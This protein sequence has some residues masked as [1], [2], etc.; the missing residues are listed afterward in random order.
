MWTDGGRQTLVETIVLCLLYFSKSFMYLFI[1]LLIWFNKCLFSM[2]FQLFI[3]NQLP[4]HCSREIF[5]ISASLP[6]YV[7][8]W[9]LPHIESHSRLPYPRS[10]ILGEVK[11]FQVSNHLTMEVKIKSYVYSHFL[12]KLLLYYNLQLQDS[13]HFTLKPT[14]PI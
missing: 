13:M 5:C 7:R 3:G 6:S 8:H 4:N 9:Q 2:L 11:W 14:S 1:Y 10:S 12:L